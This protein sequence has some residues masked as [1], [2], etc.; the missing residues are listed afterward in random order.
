MSKRFVSIWFRYLKTDWYTRRNPGLGK[1]PL[2][3]AS[4]DHGRMIITAAN[5]LAE[6]DGAFLGMPVADARALVT[7]I[8][9][10]DDD[11]NISNKLLQ[12]IAEWCIRFS[13][14]V[15]ADAPGGIILDATGCAHLWGGEKE[16]LT[17]IFSRFKTLGYTIRL[18]MADTIGMAWAAARFKKEGIIIEPGSQSAALM[19]L[20][21]EALRIDAGIVERLYQLGLDRVGEF[22]DMPN[23]AL[24][25]RFGVE[26]IKR[27][28]QA[29]GKAVEFIEPV[30]PIEPYQERLNSIDPV[31]TRTGI[32]MALEQLLGKLC[33]RLSKEGKGMRTCMF[34]CYRVDNKVQSIE[35]KTTRATFN[36]KHLF[37]LFENKIDGIE[38]ALGIELFLL[39]AN[40]VEDVSSTQESMWNGTS[41]LQDTALAELLDRLTGKFGAGKISRYLPQEHYW[42][43]RS[44]K[45]ALSLDEKPVTGWGNKPRPLQL[46]STPEIIEV[47]SLIPDYP[48]MHFRYRG[49]LHKVV[50]ADGPERIEQEWWL[51]KGLHRD[52]YCVEDEEGRRYWVF[53][54]GH[55]EGNKKPE[56]FIHGFFA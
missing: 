49:K 13:P 52:Y 43:E 33:E 26:I 15:A 45:P 3:L 40:K 9:V 8:V 55:Y 7:G 39:T 18:G 1:I 22:I 25:R 29:L 4:P 31:A 47:T 30:I 10:Q 56:W 32:E 12:H 48:P 27:L 51:Q 50:K 28:N 36:A 42:P 24:R 11:E 37:K 23:S 41:G 17:E 6:K 19:D 5:H 46:L 38:P 20:P 14:I 16:Y 34:T 53:R 54:S 2:V 44:F 21:P 35:I